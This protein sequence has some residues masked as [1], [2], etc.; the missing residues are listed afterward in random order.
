MGF[1]KPDFSRPQN[2]PTGES[3]PTSTY[4]HV[5]FTGTCFWSDPDNQL[6]YIFLSNRVYPSR[7]HKQLMEMK[8]RPQIQDIIYEAIQ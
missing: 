5:G 4:G 6:I 2:S 3:A 8:I 1:D 7:T